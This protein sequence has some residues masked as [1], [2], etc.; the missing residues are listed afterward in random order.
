[1]LPPCIAVDSLVFDSQWIEWR[2][3][4]SSVLYDAEADAVVDSD[5][6]WYEELIECCY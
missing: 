4:D 6:E 5:V 3:N 2:G 1:M